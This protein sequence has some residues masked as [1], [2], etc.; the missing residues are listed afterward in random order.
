MTVTLSGESASAH[1]RPGI[2]IVP[3]Y[4]AV[5]PGSTANWAITVTNTTTVPLDHVSVTDPK[6]PTCAMRF[7]GVLAPGASEPTYR[8]ARSD[9]KTGFTQQ[10]TVHATEDGATEAG[11]IKNGATEAGAIETAGTKA[12]ASS[13]ATVEIVGLTSG[14]SCD[15]PVYIGAAFECQYF[16]SVPAGYDTATFDS[17]TS[18]V[19]AYD[20]TVAS[21][22][23]LPSLTPTFTGGA[24]CNESQTVCTLP[25]GSSIVFAPSSFYAVSPDDYLLTNHFLDAN[26]TLMWTAEC[27]NDTARCFGAN[28]VEF[29][30]TVQQYT[31][32]VSTELTP[33]GS[34]TTG[35]A[36]T[37]QATLNGASPDAGGTVSYAVF[38]NDSCSTQVASLGSEPVNDGVAE[39][40]S[41]WTAA[42]G[43]YWFQATYSGDP[44]NQGPISSACSSE[45]LTV[46]GPDITPAPGEPLARD[47]RPLLIRRHIASSALG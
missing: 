33:S 34:V 31:P 28:Q 42:Q 35:T 22:N 11:A 7:A 27:D 5:S 8:C 39:P 14:Y 40:S 30:S 4:E 2:A 9:V 44:A 32:S 1:T 26:W 21:D 36:V 17:I 23:L 19:A 10:A 3:S 29:V 47:P 46:Q 20:G 16:L 43:S 6:A 45:P 24:S 18:Q 25:G 12:S 38:S 41:S 15:T 13:D 37:D